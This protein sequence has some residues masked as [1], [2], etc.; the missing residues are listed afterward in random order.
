MTMTTIARRVTGGVETRLDVHVVAGLDQR[1][2]LLGVE[3]FPATTAGYHKLLR[4]L[5]SFG[6]VDLVG[7]R[8]PGAMERD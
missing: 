7:S 1:G 4:R 3:S 5:E 8:A 6:H 2:S